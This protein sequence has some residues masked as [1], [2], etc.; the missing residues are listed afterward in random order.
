MTLLHKI[1]IESHGALASP[2]G[3]FERSPAGWRRKDGRWRKPRYGDHILV[4]PVRGLTYDVFGQSLDTTE[5][6]LFKVGI[7]Y[8]PDTWGATCEVTEWHTFLY[9]HNDKQF[10]IAM[11][12]DNSV[13]AQKMLFFGPDLDEADP[14]NPDSWMK[15]HMGSITTPAHGDGA[16]HTAGQAFCIPCATALTT[17]D[18]ELNVRL[19]EYGAAIRPVKDMKSLADAGLVSNNKVYLPQAGWRWI[20]YWPTIGNHQGEEDYFWMLWQN[21]QYLYVGA[22]DE[23]D[24]DTDRQVKLVD[25]DDKEPPRFLQWWEDGV[26]PDPHEVYLDFATEDLGIVPVDESLP[27]DLRSDLQQ[28]GFGEYG[29]WGW[30]KYPP[31]L[32]EKPPF[33]RYYAPLRTKRKERWTFKDTGHGFETYNHLQHRLYKGDPLSFLIYTPLITKV[34]IQ[35]GTEYKEVIL[36]H[37]WHLFSIHDE[38]AVETGTGMDIYD[39]FFEPEDGYMERMVNILHVGDNISGV[40][41]IWHEG[42]EWNIKLEHTERFKETLPTIKFEILGVKD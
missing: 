16:F 25:K 29:D 34:R 6:E 32:G 14:L 35:I 23:D 19:V 12:C 22:V 33:K 17:Y 21:R 41:G 9:P 4:F 39:D 38:E 24:E 15:P 27:L 31:R 40:Y 8:D 42:E 3:D 10:P 11:E 1:K 36:D 20:I 26:C 30:R 28:T 13:D 5:R 37:H 7:V 2:L 18:Y